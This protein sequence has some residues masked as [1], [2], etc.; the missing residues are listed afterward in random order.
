MQTTCHGARKSGVW[1]TTLQVLFLLTPSALGAVPIEEQ[2]V[3]SE[4]SEGDRRLDPL[5]H[6]A[7]LGF[8]WLNLRDGIRLS[9]TPAS[10]PVN[11]QQAPAGLHSRLMVAGD[12]DGD[13]LTDLVLLGGG[14]GGPFLRFHRGNQ[15]Q[16]D[17]VARSAT[18]LPDSLSRPVPFETAFTERRL[19]AEPE[20]SAVGD[21]D[22]DGIDDLV[23]A[24]RHE[25]LLYLRRGSATG[26]HA[27]EQRF[28]LAG[29]PVLIV[30]GEFDRRDGRS[31]LAVT[32]E[33]RPDTVFLFQSALGGLRA[34]PVEV[35]VDGEILDLRMANLDDYFPVDLLI[36]CDRGLW[37]LRGS[38]SPLPPGEPVIGVDRLPC[39]ERIVAAEVGDF[40]WDR[41]HRSDVAVVV[42]PGLVRLLEFGLPGRGVAPSRLAP[43]RFAAQWTVRKSVGLA[44]FVNENSRGHL[45]LTKGRLSTVPLD[46]LVVWDENVPALQ[47]VFGDPSRWRERQPAANLPSEALLNLPLN[48]PMDDSAAATTFLV[49]SGGSEGDDDPSDGVCDTDK[50]VAGIVCTLNAAIE[51]ANASPGMDTIEFSVSTVD[52]GDGVSRATDPLVIDGSGG[53]AGGRVELTRTA[54]GGGGPRIDA[55]GSVIRGLVIN[56]AVDQASPPYY[57]G[58]SGI[59]LDDNGGNRVENNYIGTNSSGSQAKPNFNGISVHDSAENTIGGELVSQRNVISGNAAIGLEIIGG[60][61]R[62]NIVKGNLI[63]TDVQGSQSV[64]N[65]G[66]GLAITYTSDGGTPP[67]Y[68]DRPGN[69]LIESNVISGTLQLDPL[70]DPTGSTGMGV[71]L[72]SD[73]TLMQD[74]KIGV[75]LDGATAL[76]NA[77]FGV[78]VA[79]GSGNAIIQNVIAFNGGD[80][81]TVLE[82]WEE[83][84]RYDTGYARIS[85]NSIHS[86][87]GLGINLTAFANLDGATP[88]DHLDGDSGPNDYLN[89]PVVSLND[90]KT[91]IRLTYDGLPSTEFTFEFFRNASCDP[92]GYGEGETFLAQQS[93]FG[94]NY[95]IKGTTDSNGHF[96]Q[97][98]ALAGVAD[99]II[100]AT[101]TDPDG[102]TSEFSECPQPEAGI[103]LSPQLVLGMSLCGTQER[104]IR[105]TDLLTGKEISGDAN[106]RYEWVKLDG[107]GLPDDLI[108]DGLN[109]LKK[110][111]EDLVGE[112]AQISVRKSKTAT[113]SKAYVKFNSSGINVLRAVREN[114]P[115]DIERSNYALL[116][117]GME[118][119]QADSL[120]IEP[121]ALT[122][123]VSNTLSE[124]LTHRL[125]KKFPLD[126]PMILMPPS[127][128]QCSWAVGSLGQ[129]GTVQVKSLTFQLFGEDVATVDLMDAFSALGWIPSAHPLA[130]LARAISIA[131]PVA[132]SELLSYESVLVKSGQTDPFITLGSSVPPYLNGSV[133]SRASGISAVQAT[134]DMTNYC[135]GKATDMMLVLVIPDLEAIEVRAGTGQFEDPLAVGLNE[136]RQAETVGMFDF[137]AGATQPFRLPFDKLGITNSTVINKIVA[138]LIPGAEP[139]PSGVAKTIIL[140]ANATRPSGLYQ[141]GEGYFEMRFT[142]V[143]NPGEVTIDA[144]RV[145]TALPGFVSDW[146]M[147]PDPNDI[148]SVQPDSG[149]LKGLKP[150]STEVQADVCIPFT[151]LTRRSDT[152]GV[153]VLQGGAIYVQ[154]YEDL[155]GD[156]VK[157]ANDPGLN[158][159]TIQLESA[160]DGSIQTRTTGFV[161]LDGSGSIDEDTE[162]GW[163]V[164][165]N[166]EPGVG[167]T[168]REISR[169]GWTQTSANPPMLTVGEQQ[170]RIVRIGNF[171]DM[172]VEGV[173]YEDTDGDGTRDPGEPGLSGWTIEVDLNS[174]GSIEHTTT[175]DSNG[176]YRFTHVGLG[177]LKGDR[178]FIVRE[179]PSAGWVQ[180][181][182][183]GNTPLPM[184][185]GLLARVDFGNFR[186]MT[187]R[188]RKF[189]DLNGNGT[190]DTGESGLAG[191]EIE[192]DLSRDGT[193]D[194]RATTDSSGNY[195]MLN[196]GPGDPL[197]SREL[198]VS[199]VDQPG[200]SPTF[201]TT[202]HIYPIHSGVVLVADFGNAQG[203]GICGAK[204]EDLNGN[205]IRD[206]GEPGIGGWTIELAKP[207][208][209]TEQEVTD[210][211]GGFCFS[212]LEPGNYTVR[213]ASRQAWIRTQPGGSGEYAI[214]LESG[215]S[216][217][218]IVFGNFHEAELCGLKFNDLNGDGVQGAGEPGLAGWTIR[219]SKP[220]GASVTK[221]TEAGG[222]YCFTQLGPGS[223]TI[224]EVQQTGWVQTYPASSGGHTVSTESGKTTS[225]LDF[226]NRPAGGAFVPVSICG[227]KFEDVNGDGVRQNGEPGLTG[228]TIELLAGTSTVVQSVATGAAGSY[229]FGQVGAGTYTIRETLQNGWV[230]K[231]P[232][233]AGT[234]TV[235][236]ESGHNLTG[237]DFGNFK[238]GRITGKKYN[239]LN[240]NGIADASESGLAGWT[241]FVDLNRDGVLNNPKLAGVC[242]SS[243]LEPCAKTD[244]N[245]GYT[246]GGLDIGNYALREVQQPGWRQTTTDPADASVS[247]SGSV[248][249]GMDFGN[250]ESA[251]AERAHLYFPFYQAGSGIF[252]AFAVSNY[253]SEPANV[254][255]TA[256]NEQ[257]DLC[258]FDE[259]PAISQLQA[260]HQLARLGNE[261][262]GEEGST[263]QLGWVEV[264][265]DN[266]GIGGFFQF[267]TSDLEGLDGSASISEPSSH[268]YLTRIYEFSD[269]VT[270]HI[271]VANPGDS[272]IRAVLTYLDMSYPYE[273]DA[274]IRKTFDIPARGLLSGSA[275]DLFGG[276]Q[277]AG[278][279]EVEIQDSGEAVGFE[280][281]RQISPKSLIGLNAATP[282]EQTSS[283][284][285]QLASTVDI[286]TSIKLLNTH[287]TEDR[288][289][290]VGAIEPAGDVFEEVYWLFYPEEQFEGFAADVFGIDFVNAP[291]VGT[292]RIKS[293]A[294]YMIGD[295]MF[296]DAYAGEYLAAL[297]LQTRAFR[298]AVFNHV[299]NGLGFFT[300]LAF[301]NP[302]ASA[303]QIHLRVMTPEGEKAGENSFDLAPR[304][305]TS[306][307]VDELV[308]ESNGQ[309]GGYVLIESSVPIIAQQLFGL[310]NLSLMSAVPPT[311]IE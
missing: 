94:F 132:V 165:D 123:P 86:N 117:G 172:I 82:F 252:T 240:G 24:S 38:G 197:G 10:G 213:E 44:R 37:V 221:Q 305:R 2:V 211:G 185:S 270:T 233:G 283:Y 22:G 195:E 62:D 98:L 231:H 271:A 69:N 251:S 144:L 274:T 127:T 174:D 73:G 267:G 306:A 303:A 239:D 190:L 250:V 105:V 149:L 57:S 210:A 192:L 125:G 18:R 65:S 223:H 169:T 8:P 36:V 170:A 212:D 208:G 242:D 148:A 85:R 201:P 285:A 168:A 95:D 280:L 12:F 226:G 203:T 33:G 258:L 122:S 75:T 294:P 137:F 147:I 81:V 3:P 136:E 279:I 70:L 83:E 124:F 59:S 234:H 308:P 56:G 164:F 243:A 14:D 106:I 297:Q 196:V 249:S 145:Q 143:P 25:P 225:G 153:V 262:F 295:V 21:F 189:H 78:V 246:I 19:S 215:Q 99:G 171:Q 87:D 107:T 93:W 202:G 268:F 301:Y 118:L 200:W 222:S 49:N 264:T 277:G 13:G 9:E 287:R 104:E 28:E 39:H 284:S 214:G 248:L 90:D 103:Q 247:T 77:S 253:S 41:L 161:D 288:L 281:I 142:W 109:E 126:A 276:L 311:V 29:L 100:T 129:N 61:A 6:S 224:R 188:G 162:T 218:D 111:Y 272:A 286:F 220:D 139:T 74:N 265:S 235:V 204:Y 166:L 254:K 116:I 296:G 177:D 216:R 121:L 80:G 134:F 299:A 7:G 140:P 42:A 97:T 263:P 20:V 16:I 48:I 11:L 30:A 72:A 115:A 130:W 108:F 255:F 309:V 194:R 182:P 154:K 167:Y 230:R 292:L 278:C 176:E 101:A 260:G 205:G 138:N 199:E 79:D 32:I 119:L 102:N 300:G 43:D 259:N 198:S 151:S 50:H 237:L 133:Q 120:E 35:T 89:Y 261:I 58:N 47:V 45:Q 175:T 181:A 5:L 273:P 40:V 266:P 173:K 53:G 155:L 257:G 84:D 191:W 112:V 113:Q 227:T 91:E 232:S 178:S 114:S 131:A 64:G 46:E 241:I 163:A 238:L 236:T 26:L 15:Y 31:D 96:E 66:V 217:H 183:L 55:G 179:V 282:G 88:N 290:D 1:A 68:S 76:G 128:N 23:Y 135:L 310:S 209:S 152:N 60:G 146:T 184:H 51:Q 207:D 17:S 141:D 180:T 289:V 92:S 193:V 245:G 157:D 158:G 307:T 186:F 275:A 256:Y 71:Y 160:K 34:T 302:S 269:E 156:G 219:L 54:E 150:G 52:I 27:S 229:C 304:H 4:S 63:G 110:K 206:A 159:W 244:A 67:N 298:R 228:W 293:D 187:V 291:F